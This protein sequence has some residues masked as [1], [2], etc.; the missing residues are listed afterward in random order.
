M[1]A[2]FGIKSFKP[3]LVSI[4]ICS[5]GRHADLERLVASLKAMTLSRPFEIVVVEETDDPSPIAG[6]Q[7]TS[8]P[9]VCRGIPYARN[10]AVANSS[11]SIIV[12]LDDDCLISDG[13][14]NRLLGPLIDSSV[15]GAQGGVAVPESSNA[16][17]WA[18]SMLGFPGGGIRRVC[19]ARSKLQET[20][21]ISTLNC[22]YRRWVFDKVGGFDERLRYG[23]EDYLF[24]KNACVHGRCVFVPDAVVSHRP[25]GSL[26]KVFFWFHRRGRAEFILARTGWEIKTFISYWLRSS[27]LLKILVLIILV[28]LSST[29]ALVLFTSIG[30]Y[31]V[32][33]FL[34][35]YRD[36][37]GCGAPSESFMI[38]PVVKLIMDLAI[39]CGRF[40]SLFVM[41]VFKRKGFLDASNSNQIQKEGKN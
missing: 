11:G 13:W 15:V 3:D 31:Y 24:A 18:E 6:T 25:R 9:L 39:D 8:H 38:L 41:L 4:L 17:G 7:Y 2:D 23:G 28:W 22:A 21:E 16:I 40:S 26:A 34:K 29:K 12:F 19:Q 37:Q 27:L 32:A 5:R 30:L 35:Y 14:L 33:T 36:C 20:K 1:Q 10:L